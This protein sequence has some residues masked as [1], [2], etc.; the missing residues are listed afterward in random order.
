MKRGS[1]KKV[2]AAFREAGSSAETIDFHRQIAHL[3]EES[4]IHLLARAAVEDGPEPSQKRA[5]QVLNA[6]EEGYLTRRSNVLQE[7]IQRADLEKRTPEE[8]ESLMR[9]KSEIG[10]RMVELKPSRKG[11]ELVD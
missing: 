3:R 2:V 5:V 10:R 11:K 4:D 1:V 9:E 8:V 6:L 7:R